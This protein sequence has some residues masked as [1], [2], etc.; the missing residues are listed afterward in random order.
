MAISYFIRNMQ[1]IKNQII[2]R[3]FTVRKN[4]GQKDYRNVQ[5]V[6]TEQVVYGFIDGESFMYKKN[7]NNIP[8]RTRTVYQAFRDCEYFIDMN[9]VDEATKDT[10]F[11][12][13][14][15]GRAY[16]DGYFVDG[17]KFFCLYNRAPCVEMLIKNSMGDYVKNK[18]FGISNHNAI[19]WSGKTPEK[20]F[21]VPRER[22]REI[23]KER[24]R[25]LALYIWR[26]SLK[27]GRNEK[28]KDAKV[29]EEMVEAIGGEDRYKNIIKYAELGKITR[30]VEKQLNGE[31]YNR[32][33]YVIIDWN[34][35]L[36]DCVELDLGWIWKIRT[37]YSPKIYI[38]RMKYTERK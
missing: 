38:E 13:S 37:L 1:R 22:V 18:V 9:S 11:M 2:A 30:Y 20:I 21:R 15:Y 17:V 3:T 14:Q 12:Y 5:T 32:K 34:D 28:I 4:Y 33:Y 25:E 29:V 36:R 7:W 19:N 23:I 6:V 10:R 35:Y 8:T 31:N 16:Q 24:P 27:Q 26:C